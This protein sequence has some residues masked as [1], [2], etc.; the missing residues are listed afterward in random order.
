M[1]GAQMYKYQHV[2]FREVFEVSVGLRIHEKG[3]TPSCR[4]KTWIRYLCRQD[5]FY[6]L[7]CACMNRCLQSLRWGGSQVMFSTGRVN[8]PWQIAAI[9]EAVCTL[10]ERRPATHHTRLTWCGRPMASSFTILIM[11]NRD[12]SEEPCL[13]SNMRCA[14]TVNYSDVHNNHK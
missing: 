12:L 8:R 10:L 1:K 5:C 14:Q 4:T 11:N 2:G 13:W 9:R 7:F 3:E 6:A